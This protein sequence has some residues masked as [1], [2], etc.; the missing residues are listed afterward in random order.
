MT[1]VISQGVK[2]RLNMLDHSGTID[3]I[4]MATENPRLHEELQG[5]P[6][7]DGNRRMEIIRHYWEESLVPVHAY[8]NE[9][10]IPYSD[11]VVTGS[12]FTTLPISLIYELAK[13]QF[14][15]EIDMNPTFDP[16]RYVVNQHFN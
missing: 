14:V 13:Q 10:H 16:L 4:I 2:S 6:K 9:R 7:R 5:L 3:V 12:V 15:R 8:L 1:A 11:F